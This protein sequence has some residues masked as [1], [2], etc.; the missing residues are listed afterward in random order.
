MLCVHN[1]SCTRNCSLNVGLRSRISNKTNAGVFSV[2]KDTLE[3][4]DLALQESTQA[5]K[6]SSVYGSLMY[7]EIVEKH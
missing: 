6:S 3:E 7:N 4:I 1:S 2:T 5:T